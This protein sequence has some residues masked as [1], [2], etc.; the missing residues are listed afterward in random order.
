VAD[1]LNQ[2]P[3][4]PQRH[5]GPVGRRG[6]G[7]VSADGI[8]VVADPGDPRAV[9]VHVS[10]EVDM[11]TAPVLTQQVDRLF[12]AQGDTYRPLVFDLLGVAFLGSAGLAVLAEAANR[13]AD[14]SGAVWV[15]ATS[16]TVL[17]PLQVT[18]LDSVL[19]ISADLGVAL[20]EADGSPAEAGGASAEGA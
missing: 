1:A 6:A 9:V 18:G 8:T 19:R 3:H 13:A 20:A 7:D 2:P 14:R 17:R 12:A 11:L 10:G 5:A 16:R 4:R 15:V